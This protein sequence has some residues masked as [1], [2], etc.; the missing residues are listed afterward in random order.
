MN[1]NA[2]TPGV[3]IYTI[4]LFLLLTVTIFRFNKSNKD[5]L[6]V[7]IFFVVLQ[8]LM[9]GLR[10]YTVGSDTGSYVYL[11]NKYRTYSVGE[12]I[13]DTSENDP[14][15]YLF[16][17]LITSFSDSYTFLFFVVEIIWWVLVAFTIYK[18]AKSCL[19][20]LLLVEIFKSNYFMWSGM[21]QG[22]AMALIVFAFNFLE[23][24]KV[25]KYMVVVVLAS[26]CHKSALFFVPVY[27]LYRI[28]FDKNYI[29]WGLLALSVVMA[30]VLPD[31]DFN[32]ESMAYSQYMESTG[33]SNYYTFIMI[34]LAF[35]YIMYNKSIALLDNRNGLMF[36][37]SLFAA[38]CAM[39]GINI[40]IFYR[41]SEYFCL[42]MPL[43]IS[44]LI[45]ERK[46]RINTVL[47]M[48]LLILTI[49]VVTGMPVGLNKYQFYWETNFADYVY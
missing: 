42:F 8:I 5:N 25:V 13:H 22:M 10:S 24:R 15:F 28:K 39:A 27:F 26:L 21:R 33:W 1:F 7:F 41:M 32:D 37:L 3:L 49:Y 14:Y 18:K 48:S 4:Y 43:L 20:A 11:I 16:T 44:N 38:M 19:I 6:S 35:T 17:K 36:T 34:M 2:F 29:V 40:A 31:I 47:V 23:D 45:M 12:I 30:F 9:A 46:N